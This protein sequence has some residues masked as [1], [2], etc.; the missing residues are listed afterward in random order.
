MP[1]CGER[2]PWEA[3][4][5][6][7]G[8][9]PARGDRCPNNRRITQS[10]LQPLLLTFSHIESPPHFITYLSYKFIIPRPQCPAAKEGVVG[11]GKPL[12]K[13]PDTRRQLGKVLHQQKTK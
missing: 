7:G 6:R 2:V 10:A 5:L 8:G 3:Q 13:E 1:E 4:V 12:Q 11:R 9:Q